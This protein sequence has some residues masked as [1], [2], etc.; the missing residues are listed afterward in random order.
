MRPRPGIPALALFAGMLALT[1]GNAAAQAAPPAVAP[2]DSLDDGPYVYWRDDRTALSFYHCRG[3]FLASGWFEVRGAVTIRGL[4]ADSTAT[5]TLSSRPP[6]VEPERFDGVPRIFAV[7]DIHGEY[8][9]LVELLRNAD[10]LDDALAWAWGTG[11]LVIAGDVFD[12]G[13][14]VNE[15]LWLLRRLEQEARSA[16]GRVHYLL[17]NHEVMVMRG[18]LRYVNPKYLEG[19]VVSSGVEYQDLYGPSMELGRWLRTLNVAVRING[20]LFVHGGIGP[21]VVER[22]LDLSDLNEEGRRAIDLRSYDF[23]FND[24]PG[25]VVQPDGPLWY[26]GYHRTM[27]GATMSTQEDVDRVLSHFGARAVVVGHTDVG[28]VTPLFGGKV[29]GIDVDLAALGALQ[30]LLWQ[31]GR[32]YRVAGSGALEALEGS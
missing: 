32:F 23:V 26:R 10:V 21:G 22:G 31:G 2:A 20:V 16:G 17:G 6:K 28:T 4:C 8:D 12:R 15:C 29:F 18:D 5:Y 1:A 9:A 24:M 7:S 13:D 14:Q 30:G 27:A 11:H 25:F 3:D 19:V